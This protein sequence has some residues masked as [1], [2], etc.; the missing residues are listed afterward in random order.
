MLLQWN[1]VRPASEHKFS[2]RYEVEEP[3][4]SQ[5]HH[6]EAELN[7][8]AL[9]QIRNPTSSTTTP[10]LPERRDATTAAVNHQA[11]GTPLHALPQIMQISFH[12]KDVLYFQSMSLS[13]WICS[14]LVVEEDTGAGPL[15][16]PIS[17]SLV[18]TNS[19]FFEIV[20]SLSTNFPKVCRCE[21]LQHVL[22]IQSGSHTL[23]VQIPVELDLVKMY[24]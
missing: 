20:F 14:V 11:L 23:R 4:K 10:Y 12:P 2:A 16:R 18:I 3:E 7:P 5:D 6:S 8:L 13:H 22:I 24:I 17:R 21:K 15:T 19:S 9:T 1:E